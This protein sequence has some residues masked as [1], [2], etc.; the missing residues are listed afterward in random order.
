MNDNI[1]IRPMPPVVSTGEALDRL[2][3]SCDELLCLVDSLATR[4]HPALLPEQDTKDSPMAGGA[5]PLMSS[6]TSR[7]TGCDGSIQGIKDRV[8][9]LIDRTAL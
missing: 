4:L 9:Q 1:P 2:E 8:N 3:K 7:I 5:L 6:V